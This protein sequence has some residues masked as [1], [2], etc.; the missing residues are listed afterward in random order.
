MAWQYIKSDLYRYSGKVTI[1]ALLK[2]YFTHRG[3]NFSVWLRLT[4]ANQ[5][6]SCL[7]YPIYWLKKRKYGIDILY[8]TQIG[9]GLYIG[10]SGPLVVNATAK[11]GNNVNLSQ[12]STIGAIDGPAACIGDNVY[13]GPQVCIIEQVNIGNN[14]T[15]GAGS[16][17]TKDIPDDATAAGNIARI[18][19]FEN[20][21]RYVQNRWPIN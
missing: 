6:Y 9:Y 20:P 7:A 19:N 5:W 10:H 4:A 18:L 21:G 15:I 16:I 11:L 12:Y 2:Q 1:K 17:V 13:I 14:V 8:Q 3:F